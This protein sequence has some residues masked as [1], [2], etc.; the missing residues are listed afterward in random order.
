LKLENCLL[1]EPGSTCVKITDFGLSKDVEQHSQPRT[2]KV[3]T[4]S[5]MAPE[6]SLATGDVPYNGEAADVWS[7]GVILYVLVCCDYPFGFDG[8]GGQPTHQVLQRIKD[9]AFR[10]PTDKVALSPEIMSLMSGTISAFSTV[11]AS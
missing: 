3:G 6:V 2:K 8:A 7:L 10:F 4:I 1:A 5:Y 9:G 11:L